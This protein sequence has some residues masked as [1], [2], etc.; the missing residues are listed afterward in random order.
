MHIWQLE[1]RKDTTVI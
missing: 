1:K